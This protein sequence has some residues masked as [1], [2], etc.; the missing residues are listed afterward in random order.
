MAWPC[1]QPRHP[2]QTLPLSK[3][4]PSVGRRHLAGSAPRASRTSGTD[5]ANCP[6][7][8]NAAPPRGGQDP[9]TGS[10]VRTREEASGRVAHARTYGRLL[11]AGGPRERSGVVVLAAAP[12]FEKLV[13]L[14][15]GPAWGS[16]Y[17]IRCMVFM[18]RRFSAA[19]HDVSTAVVVPATSCLFGSTW[20]FPVSARPDVFFHIFFS[21]FLQG[22]A[23][24]AC[25]SMYL[26]NSAG[27]ATTRSRVLHVCACQ[28]QTFSSSIIQE[29]SDRVSLEFTTTT[30]KFK[31]S[32][33]IYKKK[34]S[35]HSRAAWHTPELL[36]V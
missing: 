30:S 6:G 3:G 34:S 17:P 28:I 18:Q 22:K 35:N 23:T 13:P 10:G 16:L 27:V 5:D 11:L 9:D 26:K 21:F 24:R 19:V 29:N 25:T 14:P 31:T 2:W 36:G 33:H 32:N 15:R 1:Q 20:N 7:G 12:R 8:T 4:R